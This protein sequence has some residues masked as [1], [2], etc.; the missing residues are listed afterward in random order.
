MA[1]KKAAF[2]FV[3]IG[4]QKFHEGSTDALK[5]LDEKLS[6]ITSIQATKGSKIVSF[7]GHYR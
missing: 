6:E 7:Y 2:K 5:T 1:G 4:T 3:D